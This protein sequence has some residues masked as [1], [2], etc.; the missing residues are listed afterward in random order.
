[1]CMLTHASNNSQENIP[2]YKKHLSATV[3]EMIFFFTSNVKLMAKNQHEK[4]AKCLLFFGAAKKVKDLIIFGQIL[5]ND[6]CDDA[7]VRASWMHCSTFLT[8]LH[9]W[10]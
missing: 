1:M 5:L 10:L 7:C 6:R 4:A 2:P 9:L 3:R 8:N